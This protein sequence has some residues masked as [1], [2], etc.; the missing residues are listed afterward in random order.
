MMISCYV[1]KKENMN[2]GS[3]GTVLG[4]TTPRVACVAHGND[5]VTMQCHGHGRFGTVT[6]TDTS[7]DLDA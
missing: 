5:S 6:V 1:R 4:L 2:E 7:P 3:S